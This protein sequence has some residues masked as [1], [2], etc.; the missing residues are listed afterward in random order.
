VHRQAETNLG[1]AWLP[2]VLPAQA[3][4]LLVSD[5]VLA[6]ALRLAGAEL[7]EHGAEVEIAAPS[8]LVGEAPMAASPIGD[9]APDIR[10]FAGRVAARL[11]G[12]FKVRVEAARTARTLRRTGYPTTELF[13]WDP[14]HRLALGTRARTS[15]AERFSRRAVVIGRRGARGQTLLEAAVENASKTVGWPLQLEWASPR[16]G[17]TTAALDGGLLRVA[18]GPSRGQLERQAAALAIL[19]DAR[20]PGATAE[21]IPWLEARGRTGLADWSLERRMPGGRPPGLSDQFL[22]E[23]VEFL[24]RLHAAEGTAEPASSLTAIAERA[25][26]FCPAAEA[27]AIASLGESL[28]ATLGELPRGFAHGDFFPGNLLVEDG[29][30]SGVVDWD[31]SGPGRLPLLDLLHLRL[32]GEHRPADLDWGPA[33]IE[34]LVPWARR[35][36]DELTREYCRRVGMEPPPETLLAIVGAYWL[37]RLAYQLATY[38]DRAGRP[39]WIERN[40]ALV[41]RGLAA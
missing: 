31:A 4:R 15:L 24:V 23:C 36:G 14:G 17:P 30:L 3:R 2:A 22:A 34:H 9:P 16:A 7:V 40:V 25:A 19:R 41:L 27:R 28:Q 21:L 39:R 12:S 33:L 26:G 29:R 6:K 18:V 5:P 10:S 13:T 35:G 20:L 11:G 1:H 38:A 8:E 32:M 37:E